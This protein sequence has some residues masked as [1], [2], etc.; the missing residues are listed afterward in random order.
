MELEKIITEVG[1]VES[2][3]IAQEG[4][5]TDFQA[6]ESIEMTSEGLSYR[7]V[8]SDATTVKSRYPFE[9]G[10]D[11]TYN[12]DI[13]EDSF[14]V[15]AYIGT[16]VAQTINTGI[17]AYD[18]NYDAA[19]TM[20]AGSGNNT[21]YAFD[22]ATMKLWKY[23]NITPAAGATLAEGADFT[24]VAD[25][26]EIDFKSSKAW[27]KSINIV[28]HGQVFDT[29]RGK[30]NNLQTSE[31]NAESNTANFCDFSNEGITIGTPGSVNQAAATYAVWQWAYN[32]VK[33]TTTNQGKRALVAF[34][35]GDRSIV[36]YEGSG[37]T[38]HEVPH[39]L[40][41]AAQ[42][43]HFKAL[44][45]TFNW[46]SFYGD[47]GNLLRL[48]SSIAAYAQAV[49]ITGND[50]TNLILGHDDATND[51]NNLMIAYSEASKA[52]QIKVGTYTGTNS[53]NNYVDCG[54]EVEYVMI[55]RTDAAASWEILDSTRGG[56][57]R[58]W[59]DTSQASITTAGWLTFEKNGFRLVH[60][61]TAINGAGNYLYV[62]YAKGSKAKKTI[63]TDT[64]AVT[65]VSTTTAKNFAT[66]P[67][68]GTGA[69]QA[70]V[71]GISSVDF[72]VSANGSDRWFDRSTF[73]V[74]NDAGTVIES[75]I[76]EVN[77]SKVHIKNLDLTSDHRV[78]DSLRGI[79]QIIRTNGTNAESLQTS[80][81]DAFTATGFT[82]GGQNTNN[83]GNDFVVY[84][85]LYTHVRWGTTNHNKKYIE[86]FNPYTNETMV[87]YQGSGTA[88]HSIPHSLGIELDYVEAKSL[89]A[90]VDWTVMTEENN[91]LQLNTTSAKVIGA[92]TSLSSMSATSNTVTSGDAP[93]NTNN[94]EYIMYGKA[95]SENW[96]I[97]EYTGTGAAGNYVETRDVFGNPRRPRRVIFKRVDGTSSWTVIDSERGGSAQTALDLSNAE[98]T[99]NNITISNTGFIITNIGAAT[100]TSG[101]KYI[102]MAEFDTVGDNGDSYYDVYE[103]THNASIEPTSFVNA[104]DTKLEWS[105][106]DGVTYH[107]AVVATRSEVDGVVTTTFNGIIDPTAGNRAIKHKV[108]KKLDGSTI[109]RI[110]ANIKKGE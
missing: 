13:I 8:L 35:E 15:V 98:Y 29:L 103:G 37:V 20:T 30:D 36:L 101:G 21:E 79:N 82:L 52:G 26:V 47:V 39:G 46:V 84:Q 92:S 85:T 94:G 31:T 40:G 104:S 24:E 87:F 74:K 34:T 60:T 106:N 33:I 6:L 1:V 72:T 58:I 23:I 42:M 80:E 86:A 100:N 43:T 7:N 16:G 78:F 73:E 107:E 17:G 91:R 64:A 71:T 96:T 97:V 75:G 102:A 38:G 45:S 57:A 105:L 77:T 90:V 83:N 51:E 54:F 14:A 88:G 9:E 68:T 62:A 11:L 99:G 18:I 93:L 41:T 67:Y 10:D 44:E 53:A 50:S 56:D 12:G 69:S 108:T 27:I 81:F 89:T 66:I 5:E 22:R 65:G 55:K 70:I 61:S 28:K 49:S 95:K 59:S 32:K 109:S 3:V 2:T 76:V 4:G 19:R 48:N 25:D 110:R 63:G